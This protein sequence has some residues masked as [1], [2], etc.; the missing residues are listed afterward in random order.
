MGHILYGVT[1]LLAQW[2]RFPPP[3]DGPLR[4]GGRV[5]RHL[6]GRVS[7]RQ[8]VTWG[9]RGLFK[10]AGL[11]LGPRA[12]RLSK[13]PGGL[14]CHS[15]RGF[16]AE[17]TVGNSPTPG[18]NATQIPGWV[19]HIH[20]SPQKRGTGRTPHQRSPR[21]LLSGRGVSACGLRQTDSV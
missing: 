6:G 5:G 14:G 17:G 16:P 11:S 21:L 1:C 18:E 3:T 9:H 20:V 4:E 15:S 19:T 8:S 13:S 7:G 10:V 12:W 2:M